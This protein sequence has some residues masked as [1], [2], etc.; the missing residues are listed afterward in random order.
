MTC[1]LRRKKSI[2]LIL[3]MRVGT[4]I[5]GIRLCQI[6]MATKEHKADL[7]ANTENRTE[8]EIAGLRSRLVHSYRL[9]QLHS[10][11]FVTTNSIAKDNGS[12]YMA[13]NFGTDHQ[14]HIAHTS[15]KW[16][17]L[18]SRWRNNGNSWNIKN[19]G[20]GKNFIRPTMIMKQ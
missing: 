2:K 12:Y 1:S 7:R 16:A 10:G 4:Y 13:N 15:F 3:R 19:R 8:L 11:A 14:I 17:N 9:Q 20:L 6:Y 18:W 5:C